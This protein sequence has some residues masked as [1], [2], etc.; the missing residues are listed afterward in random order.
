MNDF[1]GDETLE[2]ID[3]E[4]RMREA[5]ML[6]LRLRGGLNLQSFHND[7]G[8]NLLEEFAETVNKLVS[9]GFVEVVDQK[10][11]IT[12]R[13]VLISNSIISEFF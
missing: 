9:G 10:L 4:T 3:H 5:I 11:R 8:I 7:F 6:G 1:L 2:T 13:G 12:D